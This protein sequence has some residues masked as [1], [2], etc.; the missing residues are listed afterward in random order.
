MVLQQERVRC[1]P[2]FSCFKW[3]H[4]WWSQ[5]EMVVS[6]LVSLSSRVNLTWLFF[7]RKDTWVCRGKW[8]SNLLVVGKW[9]NPAVVVVGEGYLL[10]ELPGV[11]ALGKR[12]V[13]QVWRGRVLPVHLSSPSLVS[14][15]LAPLPHTKVKMDVEEEPPSS[16][17]ESVGLVRRKIK[18]NQLH[19]WEV[20]KG[21]AHAYNR[22]HVCVWPAGLHSTYK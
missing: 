1:W 17:N 18:K 4:R 5:L 16:P 19:L 22:I 13:L 6:G 21:K 20:E 9:V 11:S 10:K 8:F 14:G 2:G 3:P 12:L 7:F 15:P